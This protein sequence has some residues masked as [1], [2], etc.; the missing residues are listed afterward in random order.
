MWTTGRVVNV[1]SD[2]VERAV[3]N[4]VV[5]IAPAPRLPVT[6]TGLAATRK[7]PGISAL[8]SFS[9]AMSYNVKRATVSGGP[10]TTIGSVSGTNCIDATAVN[11][12]TYYYVVS[13]LNSKG[14]SANSAQVSATPVAHCSRRHP[15]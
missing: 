13:A 1:P 3:A 2:G 14:E 12:T 10:Y 5:I 7:A 11:G 6:P 15:V 8:E 9:G 4:A